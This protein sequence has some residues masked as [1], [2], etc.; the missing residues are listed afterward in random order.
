MKITKEEF[1]KEGI[2]HVDNVGMN[3]WHDPDWM[4]EDDKE[5][6]EKVLERLYE[7]DFDVDWA[8]E[9]IDENDDEAQS[10]FIFY[11]TKGLEDR[12]TIDGFCEAFAIDK[13]YY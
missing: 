7:K 13:Y 8:M 2:I 12:R 11:W 3:V 6:A 5:Y 4:D 9:D 1:I 10:E